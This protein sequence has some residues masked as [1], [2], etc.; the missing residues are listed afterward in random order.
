MNNDDRLLKEEDYYKLLNVSK[1][2]DINVINK[3]YRALA[4]IYHPD[5]NPGNKVAEEIFKKLNE[6]HKVLQDPKKR[7]VYDQ[8]GKE[9]ANSHD[10]GGG[11]PNQGFPFPHGFPF[12]AQ[13]FPF[14]GMHNM[15]DMQEES[16]A[17]PD[18][19][20]E[21]E[22]TLEEIYNGTKKK[23]QFERF[24]IC[25]K[26]NG[27]GTHDKSSEINCKKCEGK[28]TVIYLNGFGMRQTDCEDCKGTG[29]NP[30]IDKCKD[31]N[32]KRGMKETT[33]VEVNFEP[34][35]SKNTP[36]IIND[37][38]NEIPKDEQ[39]GNTRSNLIISI[40]EKEHS[41]FTRGSI[42][43]E[44]QNDNNLIMELKIT[45][46]ESLCGV[47]KNI[48]H[49]DGSHFKVTIDHLIHN[50][51]VFVLKGKGI[52][53][54]RSKGDMIIKMV[55]EEDNITSEQKEEIWKILS[56]KPYKPVTKSIKQLM[57]FSDYKKELIEDLEKERMKQRYRH[58]GGNEE[59]VGVQC[60][61]Q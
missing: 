55:I 60:A 11:M 12:G 30:K 28:G 27:K 6:A 29:L 4:K 25:S 47:D 33:S 15:N 3:A 42:L 8:F 41:V 21:V 38:G 45:L 7:Q 23:V 5:R 35:C 10:H 1:D 51:D 13:G 9:A 46:A 54:R 48:K 19:E 37:S 39:R 24:N 52:H 14:A 20:A 40:S 44:A 32:G 59:G 56:D 17:V 61:Q 18:C 2:A 16:N 36:I 58:K 22:L 26:C 50:Q 34:G 49:L 53:G 31:C 43:K 57:K